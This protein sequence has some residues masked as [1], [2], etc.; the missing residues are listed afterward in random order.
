MRAVLLALNDPGVEL[1]R[2][3][4]LLQECVE[5]PTLAAE[6][7]QANSGRTRDSELGLVS[8]HE[9]H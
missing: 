2:E 7:V 1:L 8:L 5:G 4:V 9:S 6:Q 3:P